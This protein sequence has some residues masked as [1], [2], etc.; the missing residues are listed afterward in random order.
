MGFLSFFF[1]FL[2]PLSPSTVFL[3]RKYRVPNLVCKEL[4]PSFQIPP[5][6]LKAGACDSGLTNQS[7][8]LPWPECRF[9]VGAWPRAG[10]KRAHGLEGSGSDSLRLTL[11]RYEAGSVPNHLA[12]WEARR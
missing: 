12:P 6:E 1:F 10:L 9:R 11:A 8:V 5:K 4:P 3:L 2:L 7:I